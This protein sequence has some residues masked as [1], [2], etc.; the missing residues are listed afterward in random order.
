LEILLQKNIP[1]VA[2]QINYDGV[3]NLIINCEKKQ[4]G[5]IIFVSTCSNYGLSETNNLLDEN[6]KAATFVII[7]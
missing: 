7:R 3:K 2:Q 4:D 1:E 6:A 5:K